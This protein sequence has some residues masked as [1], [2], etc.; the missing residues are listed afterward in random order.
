MTLDE[1][2]EWISARAERIVR[3]NARL[4]DIDAAWV[5]QEITGGDALPYVVTHGIAKAVR[6]RVIA[7]REAEKRATDR[8][9][10]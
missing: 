3:E 4:D 2:R 1:L 6:H 7:L 10:L 9:E 8:R 5:T